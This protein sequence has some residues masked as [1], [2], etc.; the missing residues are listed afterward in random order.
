M[1]DFIFQPFPT[2]ETELQLNT[3]NP[4][5]TKLFTFNNNIAADIYI[6]VLPYFCDCS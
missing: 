6:S 1:P 5:I 3:L 4:K 2:L